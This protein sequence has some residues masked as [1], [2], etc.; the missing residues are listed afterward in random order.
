MCAN[1]PIAPD[2]ISPG[3]DAQRGSEI[4][5]LSLREMATK[6]SSLK[7]FD[8]PV[9]NPT[10]EGQLLMWS[11]PLLIEWMGFRSLLLST[12]LHYTDVFVILGRMII[13]Q[14]EGTHPG[15]TEAVT[16]FFVGFL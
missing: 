6:T 5:N 11:L 9:T 1:L 7:P 12:L 8:T 4:I 13:L 16:M 2:K 14:R 15:D 3:N 10:L